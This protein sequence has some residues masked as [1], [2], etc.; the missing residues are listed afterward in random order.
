MLVSER[1]ILSKVIA[2]DNNLGESR[3]LEEGET[4]SGD[5]NEIQVKTLLAL[6]NEK[7]LVGSTKGKSILKATKRP[8]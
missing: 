8:F 4:A 6:L 7:I 5:V 3:L 1:T 2:P